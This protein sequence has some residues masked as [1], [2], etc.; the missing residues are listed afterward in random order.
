MDG[1]EWGFKQQTNNGAITAPHN[2]ALSNDDVQ[3]RISHA[4]SQSDGK[5]GQTFGSHCQ[6]WDSN[7]PG[8]Y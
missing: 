4:Q 3:S 8:E 6:Y 5:F 7:H 1:G 2:L